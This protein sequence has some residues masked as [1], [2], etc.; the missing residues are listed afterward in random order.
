MHSPQG[1][2]HQNADA[3][4]PGRSLRSAEV[5]AFATT[6]SIIPLRSRLDG[7]RSAA[8]WA[9]HM[10]RSWECWRVVVVTV[11]MSGG[12]TDRAPGR[13]GNRWE[14]REIAT[15]RPQRKIWNSYVHKDGG[16]LPPNLDDLHPL[17]GR[18][19]LVGEVALW[20]GVGVVYVHGGHG[21]WGQRGPRKV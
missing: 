2:S 16:C 20:C 6:R 3:R 12:H 15:G 13:K 19:W 1:A 21:G 14:T 11:G 7:G 4:S 5:C 9:R 17:D 10:L 8:P 18:P